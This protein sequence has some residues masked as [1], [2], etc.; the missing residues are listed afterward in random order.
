MVS[1][2]KLL[3]YGGVAILGLGAIYFAYKQVQSAAAKKGA[4]GALTGMGSSAMKA[5][6]FSPGSIPFISKQQAMQDTKLKDMPTA[7]PLHGATVRP[8]GGGLPTT[9]RTTMINQA[10]AGRTTP[11]IKPHSYPTPAA[12]RGVVTTPTPSRVATTARPVAR[13][14]AQ[15]RLARRSVRGGARATRSPSTTRSSGRS[16]SMYGGR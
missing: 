2:G 8:T 4:L 9:T 3:L 10:G 7:V 16:R 11:V 12:G 13:T 1:K 6:G 15:P 14:A 5:I